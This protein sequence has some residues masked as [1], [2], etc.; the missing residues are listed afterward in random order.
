ML[1]GEF[2]VIRNCSFFNSL[3]DKLGACV[4]GMPRGLN[5]TLID[6]CLR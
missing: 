5:C 1:V 2:V 6:A 4:L 3:I